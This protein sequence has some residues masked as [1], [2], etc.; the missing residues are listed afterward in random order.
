LLEANWANRIARWRHRPARPQKEYVGPADRVVSLSGIKSFAG[1]EVDKQNPVR[2]IKI[3]AGTTMGRHRRRPAGSPALRGTG[4]GGRR[5]GGPQIRN[6]GRSAATCASRNRCWYF[7]DEHVNC[8]LKGG[9]R[10]FAL[11]GEN[12]YHAVFTQGNP[13]VIVHPST[14]APGADRPGASVRSWAE[15]RRR[16]GTWRSSSSPPR[17]QKDREHTLAP[18]ELVL[19]VTVPVRGQ[20]LQL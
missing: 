11:D 19:S 8:L 14:L 4:D 20:W 6:M 10:C 13:C 2:W 16:T 5:V 12:R 17:N 7:R 3:G 1:I 9:N 18:N 15:R